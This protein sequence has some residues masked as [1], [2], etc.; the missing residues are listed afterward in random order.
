MTI[1][2]FSIRPAQATDAQEMARLSGDLGYPATT[3]EQAVRLE[4]ALA[5]PGIGVM[6]AAGPYGLWGWVAV[7]QR[8]S[9]LVAPRAEIVAL[10]VDAEARECGIGRAL[11][12]MAETWARERGLLRLVVRSNT[13]RPAAHPFYQHLGY[14]R[15]KS[16]HVYE[17]TLPE[18]LLA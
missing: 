11:V 12:E 5:H 10:V 8:I 13:S 18:V 16:Q 1:P 3:A 9:L 2:I 14:A 17:K 6:V 15:S 4:A 7:E